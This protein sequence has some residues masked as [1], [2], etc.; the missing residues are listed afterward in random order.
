MTIGRV[1]CAVLMTSLRLSSMQLR[2]LGSPFTMTRWMFFVALLHSAGG[3]R[4]PVRFRKDDFVGAYKT[5]PLRLEDLQLAV[6]VWRDASGSL[7]T[8]QLHCCPFGAVA[9]VHAWHRIGAAV[10]CIL[11]NLFLVVYARYVD[12]LFSLDEVEQPDLVSDFIGPTG[13][14]TLARRVI[15]ELLGWELDAEKAVTNANVFVALGVQ[16]EYV[17]RSQ[18][19]IFA[20]PKNVQPNGASRSKVICCHSACCHLRP[21]NLRKAQLGCLVRVWPW[22]AGAPR[23]V[24]LSCFSFE[25][26]SFLNA[27]RRRLSGGSVSWKT[28][29][30]AKFLR[31]QYR[32]L[33]SRY[34]QMRLAMVPLLG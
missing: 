21:E 13:T 22:S 29:R 33:F 28:C 25:S 19:M 18:T 31:L 10:Q 34:T 1:E 4:K 11:A 9:S 6:T 8:L 16:V 30:F 26:M 5:L 32:R 7:R 14:A 12:D 24:V 20:L 27:C 3:S 2:H 15:Q 17:D 23:P